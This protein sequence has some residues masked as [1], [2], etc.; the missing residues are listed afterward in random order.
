MHG[1]IKHDVYLA[2]GDKDCYI[3]AQVLDIL[4]KTYPQTRHE[5]ILLHSDKILMPNN[6]AEW[7]ER[8]F[9][10]H[11][12]IALATTAIIDVYCAFSLETVGLVLSGGG[13][14]GWL[15]YV[16][17][18]LIDMDI[19]IDAVGGTSVGAMAGLCFAMYQSY[20]EILE[21][22]QNVAHVAYKI[23][24]LTNLTLPVIS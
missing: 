11:H 18:A 7:L 2:N 8:N 19:E 10:L 24:S 6:T 21:Q 13:A 20:P 3:D 17:K 15:H 22:F 14:K 1:K 23:T 9:S 4:N 5:L 12:H 16:I